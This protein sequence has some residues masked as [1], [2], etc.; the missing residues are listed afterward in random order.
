MGTQLTGRCKC[1]YEGVAYI[2]SGR[3]NHGKVF[4]YPH[5]CKT[6]LSL[7]SIDILS[8]SQ[9]CNE[10]GSADVHSY[11]APTR[12]LSYKSLLNKLPTEILRKAGYHRSEEVHEETFCYPINKRFVFLRKPHFCPRC[13]ENSLHF[14]TSML[15][16]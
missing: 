2:A 1:G 3:A 13:K 9:L 5:Y 4:K 14:F 10:C 11:E 6:C 12:T 16:D 15:F 8:D 7:T